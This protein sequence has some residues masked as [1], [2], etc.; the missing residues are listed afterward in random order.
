MV[1]FITNV[2]YYLTVTE[3]NKL[4]GAAIQAAFLSGNHNNV[5]SKSVIV[6]DVTTL[7]RLVS[8]I[9]PRETPIPAKLNQHYSSTIDNQT[10][11]FFAVLEG[12]RT[13]VEKNKLLGEMTLNE[14]PVMPRGEAKMDV[15]FFIDDYGILH[16]EAVKDNQPSILSKIFE[17]ERLVADGNNLL[18]EMLIDVPMCS[19]GVSTVELTFKVEIDGF[20]HVSAIETVPSV[21]SNVTMKCD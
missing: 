12:E 15:T 6:N 17:G 4:S 20:L 19:R 16:A 10:S 3:F 7:S 9:N 13:I 2:V 18:G 1:R 8:V 11:C 14:F 21:K 5:T